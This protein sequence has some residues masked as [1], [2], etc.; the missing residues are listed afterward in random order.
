MQ[1]II[2]IDSL[3]CIDPGRITAT[4][5]WGDNHIELDGSHFVQSFENAFKQVWV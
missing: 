2:H 3:L 1:A 5:K 4:P